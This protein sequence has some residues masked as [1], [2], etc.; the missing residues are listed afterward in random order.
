MDVIR[1]CVVS[2]EDAKIGKRVVRKNTAEKIPMAVGRTNAKKRRHRD[3][4]RGRSI[5]SSGSRLYVHVW[6]ICVIKIVCIGFVVLFDL[7]L[8][9]L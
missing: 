9:V 6:C 3:L 7:C 1:F 4:A 5:I 8:Y 2:E